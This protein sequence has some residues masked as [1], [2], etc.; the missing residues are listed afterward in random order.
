MPRLYAETIPLNDTEYWST[1]CTVFDTAYDVANLLQAQDIAKALVSHPEN[2]V[3]LVRTLSA[4]VERI[5]GDKAFPSVK[6][7]DGAGIAAY[8]PAFLARENV[9]AKKEDTTRLM[10]NCLRVLSR[11]V[12]CLLAHEDGL[13]EEE[14]FWK[15]SDS[16]DS[17][18]S[19]PASSSQFVIDDDGEDDTSK[20]DSKAKHTNVKVNPVLAEKLLDI[21]VDLL[22]VHG[23]T[24]P[25][26]PPQAMKSKVAYSIWENGIGSNTSVPV[27][28]ECD[29]NR[30][31]VLRFLLVLMSK[32]L[33]IPSNA[34]SGYG[35]TQADNRWHAHFVKMPAEAKSRKRLLSLLCSLLN[36]SLKS[37]AYYASNAGGLVGAVG[38]VVGESY[39]KLVSGGKHREDPTRLALV[40][41]AV[42]FLNVLLCIPTPESLQG[43]DLRSPPPTPSLNRNTSMVS[44]LSQDSIGGQAD[45]N[46]FVHYLSKL[47]RA[48]D[49]GFI[50]E[51]GLTPALVA[52]LANYGRRRTCCPSCFNR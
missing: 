47:H 22:F 43:L 25:L 36:T 32:T 50:V 30:A 4:E 1:F 14:V 6:K 12:P 2:V 46:A 23:F 27:S 39:E 48:S 40:K 34:L 5:L 16:P 19:L 13:L 20:S 35:E 18:S 51:V 41:V 24:L 45:S 44:I 29:G 38:G 8:T 11:V 15:P 49:V 21:A 42:Q 28:R 52:P 3:A 17:S 33:Y 10:L 7:A 9:E 31:E 26:A 37:G